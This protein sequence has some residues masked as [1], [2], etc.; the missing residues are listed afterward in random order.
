MQPKQKPRERFVPL[1][2]CCL[3][4]IGVVREGRRLELQVPIGSRGAN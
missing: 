1:A 2:C 4:R 3:K